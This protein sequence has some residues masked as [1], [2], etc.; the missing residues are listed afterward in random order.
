MLLGISQYAFGVYV[1]S[2]IKEMQ[3]KLKNVQINI[4]IPD[5]IIQKIIGLPKRF[6][7][8]LVL[9]SSMVR[10]E[11][12]RIVATQIVNIAIE[13]IRAARPSR[14]STLANHIN[15]IWSSASRMNQLD[16]FIDLIRRSIVSLS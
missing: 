11:E 10:H 9:S 4:S 13:K 7:L 16:P 1:P 6:L 3:F 14:L 2:W 15:L 12:L 5:E 8:A